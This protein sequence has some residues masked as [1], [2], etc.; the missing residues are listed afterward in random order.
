[1]DINNMTKAELIDFARENGIAVNERMKKEDIY[2]SIVQPAE[3]ESPKIVLKKKDQ[4][5]PKFHKFIKG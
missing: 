3:S 1:M 4:V 2:S 5:H